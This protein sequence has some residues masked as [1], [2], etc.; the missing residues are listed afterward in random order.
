M[1]VLAG[2]WGEGPAFLQRG[3]TGGITGIRM[4]SGLLGMMIPAH[5]IVSVATV[6]N[7]NRTS[8]LGKA[9]WGVAGG[10]LLGPVGALAGILGG[11]N[12]QKFV[13]AIEFTADRRA[14]LECGADECKRLMAMSFNRAMGNAS[15]DYSPQ[16]IAHS[17]PVQAHY[18]PQPAAPYAP[19]PS[20]QSV[21]APP[22]TSGI[23]AFKIAILAIVGI[24]VLSVV[25]AGVAGKK[26]TETAESSATPTLSDQVRSDEE[27]IIVPS[28][29]KAQYFVM[30]RAGDAQKPVWTT[31]RVGPS[32]T[33]FTKRAF[34]CKTRRVQDLADGDSWAEFIND[35]RRPDAPYVLV[36]GSIADVLWR[37]ACSNAQHSDASQATAKA[38]V[39][40]SAKS[41][42]KIAEAPI[43]ASVRESNST[44]TV[45]SENETV[46]ADSATAQTDGLES[47]ITT[48]SSAQ[49]QPAKVVA[50]SAVT[51]IAGEVPNRPASVPGDQADALVKICIDEHGAVT[52]ARL[53]RGAPALAAPLQ[54]AIMQWV[55][56]PFV[57]GS[58]KAVP[59]CF[60][61]SMRLEPGE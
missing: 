39:K 50:G 36:D 37:H 49:R 12:K 56:A 38:A 27:R 2:S 54:A 24:L 33:S 60:A 14:L 42:K 40:S 11:G 4:P 53:A 8:V 13:L 51:K 32:G 5:D 34:Y 22:R 55:Y 23:G 6:T 59:V 9:G 3:W 20:R 16:S 28:D 31:R 19:S 7:E 52:S 29:P 18:A 10:L 21:Y 25:V 17:T 30:E 46:S 44:A 47:P 41:R 48:P 45:A 58:G 26:P 35:S 15:A 1:K 57:D 43:G 61:S